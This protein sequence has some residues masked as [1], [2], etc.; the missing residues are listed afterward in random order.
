MSKVPSRKNLL[1]VNRE[2][3][4]RLEAVEREKRLLENRN[5]RLERGAEELGQVSMELVRRLQ[6]RGER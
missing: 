6:A 1:R 5:A 4:A 3:A 2:L